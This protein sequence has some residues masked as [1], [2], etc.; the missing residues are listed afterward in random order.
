M[1]A[2]GNMMGAAMRL[3]A[4]AALLL[5]LAG[6]QAQKVL[7][8]MTPTSTYEGSTNLVYDAE[9][10]LKLDVYTPDGAIA[11]PVV[12]FFYG[13]RW[14]QG[15]KSLYRFVGQAL[16]SRGFVAVLPDLRK[17]PQAAFPEFVEDGAQAVRWVREQVRHYGGD[18]SRVFVMG[19]SSG[20]HVAALLAMDRRYL[21]AVGSPPPLGFI[22]LAGPYDFLPL[23]DPDLQQIFAPASTP[24]QTQQIRYVTREAPPMLLIHGEDDETVDIANSQRLAAAARDAGAAVELVEYPKMDHAR[25]I[26]AL[27]APLRLLGNVLDEIEQFVVRH[28]DRS[29]GKRP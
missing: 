25:V 9:R 3:L 11:S 14:Q 24:E 15:D 26:G 18:P 16:S 12:V 19:H 13:G 29:G 1:T 5:S 17:F 2:N 7:N 22:G 28:A 23:R 6:C 4:G 27:A 10:G 8:A 20:A 21:N